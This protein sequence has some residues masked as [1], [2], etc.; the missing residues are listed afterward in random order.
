MDAR[1]LIINN[2][3]MMIAPLVTKE[4]LVALAFGLYTGSVNA[5]IQLTAIESTESKASNYLH[6]ADCRWDEV[7]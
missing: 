6:P 7:A 3:M 5:A 1:D 4:T 2:M